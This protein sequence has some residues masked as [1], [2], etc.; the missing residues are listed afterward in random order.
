MGRCRRAWLLAAASAAALAAVNAN[1]LSSK[2]ASERLLADEAEDEDKTVPF[3]SWNNVPDTLS[4]LLAFVLVLLG[5]HLL[6]LFFPKYF[7]LPLITGYL[8][9]GILSGPF[10][11]N[12]LNEDVVDMLGS[13]VNA[14][15]LSFISFQAGQEIYLPELRPQIKSILALLST[16]YCTAMVLGTSVFILA[17][18]AFFYSDLA[19]SCQLGIALMFASISVLVSPST[20]MALKIEL[21]NVGPFTHLAL[22]TCMT[23][24]FVV[25]VSFSVSRVVASIYCAKLDVSPVSIVFTMAVVLMNLVLGALLGLVIILI[26]QIPSGKPDTVP[27]ATALPAHAISISSGRTS[28]SQQHKKMQQRT[29]SKQDMSDLE[30]A[31]DDPDQVPHPHNASIE[32]TDSDRLLSKPQWWT[33]RKALYLKGFIWLLIGYLFYLFTNTLSELTTAHFGLVWQVKFEALLVLMLA[34]CAAGHYAAIRPQMHVI[35]DTVAPYMFLP[36]FVMTGASLQLDKV[37][38]VLPL[39]SLYLVLRYTAIFLAIYGG[40]RFLLKLPPRHYKH[41]WLTMAPQAGVSL[42]LAAEVMELITDDWGGRVRGN[43]RGCG[44]D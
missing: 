4:H 14:F 26:F 15:A 6:G 19:H 2:L 9:A 11:A 16:Y 21:N 12:L 27:G 43:Y 41:L 3:N 13:Y 23:A 35:L 10:L 28:T 20:V 39:M 17:A 25:L 38:D 42:G 18:G 24:E 8:V 37:L 30:Q 1:T 7:Y 44:G 5:A 22:G 33:E 31:I 34:S 32:E 40:G 29:D 36:F